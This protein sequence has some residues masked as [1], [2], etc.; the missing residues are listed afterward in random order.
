MV[1]VEAIVSKTETKIVSCSQQD[2]ELR[3]KS[4]WVVSATATNE[5]PLLLEDASRPTPI[6]K[7]QVRYQLLDCL[8]VTNTKT[9]ISMLSFMQK[10]E[11]KRIEAEI[12]EAEANLAAVKGMDVA[13]VLCSST[14]VI[15]FL[16]THWFFP[17]IFDL[18]T[19]L[20][21]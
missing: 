12:K 18:L 14:I 6:L 4:L 1:D 20:L 2:V 7:A 15:S 3:I 16:Y 19:T 13:T 5:L 21:C 17:L 9:I 11:I 10:A 8:V